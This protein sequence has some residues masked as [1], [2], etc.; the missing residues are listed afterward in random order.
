MSESRNR[1]GLRRRG[2]F[3]LGAA[4][5]VASACGPVGESAAPVTSGAA[6]GVDGSVPEP[7]VVRPSASAASGRSVAI[8]G[9]GVGG[10][11]AAQELA[12]R[13]FAVTVYERK[14]LGGKARSNTVPGTGVGR[15]DL[16]GEH[17][18]RGFLGF[19]HNLY[20][21]LE[22]IPVPEGGRGV[23]GRLVATTRSVFSREGRS[24]ISLPVIGRAAGNAYFPQ[25]LTLPVVT[26][27]LWSL[28][29]SFGVLNYDE[30]LRFINRLLVYM[31]SSEERRFGEWENMT[32][33]DFLQTQGASQEYDRLF[34][35]GLTR[36]LAAMRSD[37]A[38]ANSIGI[39]GEATVYSI[40]G[41]GLVQGAGSIDVLHGATNEMWIHPWVAHLQSIGVRFEVGLTAEQIRCDAGGSVTSVSVRDR[42]GVAREISADYYVLAMP[43]E[44]AAPL[45][46]GDV[47]SFDPSLANL[48]RLRTDWMNGMQFYMRRRTDIAHGGLSYVD[49]P[50]A[51]TSISQGQFWK[52]NLSAYGDGQVADIVSVAIADWTTPGIL[53]G[54]T[55]R[56][57]TRDEIAREVWAQMKSHLN[58][59]LFPVLRDQDLHSWWIDPAI[60]GTGTGTAANDEPL[61]IQTPGSWQNR[62]E[63]ITG[64]ENLFLAAD[65]VRTSIHVTT[66]EGANTA[67][68]KAVNGILTASGSTSARVPVKEMWMPPEFEVL[69]NQDRLRYLEGK[70]HLLDLG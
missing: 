13:G 7:T 66:M 27:T 14:E 50:W 12:E 31:T 51:V 9:G 20:E 6:P 70:P 48:A 64:L 29:N 55:A 42:L 68:R 65:Y 63:A 62:P 43:V 1:R 67:A 24:D 19:Y 21:L 18:Y 58:D 41:R 35:H 17:G 46:T 54:K 2:L 8:F 40:L 10:L 49:S 4:G 3:K 57:C 69:K 23:R 28:V 59:R 38:S 5:L 61:L 15:P 16:P 39:I 44:R 34:A 60:T 52:R 53:Y 22:R 56:E 36:N 25:D 47:V 37:E 45:M 30:G 11:S 26:S 33:N 32:W